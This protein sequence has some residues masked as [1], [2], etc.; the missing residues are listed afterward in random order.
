MTDRT[1]DFVAEATKLADMFGTV[2]REWLTQGQLMEVRRRNNAY[3]VE[4][5]VCASHEFCDANMA[6]AD[7][8]ELALGRPL[9]PE[10]R[11]GMAPDDVDLVNEAWK[12]AKRNGF[13]HIERED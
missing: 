2:L 11:D 10:D 3:G 13:K 6:M 4:A 8:F 5:D 9:L 1:A 12:I 7:A